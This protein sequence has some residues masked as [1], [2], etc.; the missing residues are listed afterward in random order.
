ME[1]EFSQPLIAAM[2]RIR[3]TLHEKSARAQKNR[4]VVSI[5]TTY[6]SNS[7]SATRRQMEPL[8]ETR[9]SRRATARAFK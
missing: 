4:Q 1:F 6:R 2:V 5:E 7:V 3:T 9:E 8:G